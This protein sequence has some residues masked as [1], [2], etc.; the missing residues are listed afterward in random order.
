MRPTRIS[1]L[2]ALLLGFAAASWGLFRL[3]EIRGGVLP[4]LSWSAPAG[5]FALGIVVLVTALGL[6]SRIASGHKRPHPLSMARMAVLG[7]ASAHVG[8]IVGGIYAGYALVL[9]PGL[10]IVNRR[11]R[12]VLAG[13]ALVA[14]LV[15]TAAGLLLERTCRVRGVDD[16]D[17]FGAPA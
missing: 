6:R 4:P 11:D 12:A 8:P 9:L 3:I 16:S 13:G 15:L 10:D 7:K 1:S 17:D 14:A 2:V 5:V